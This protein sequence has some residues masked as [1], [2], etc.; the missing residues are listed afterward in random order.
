MTD[1]LFLFSFGPL[2]SFEHRSGVTCGF[3][4][5]YILLFLF[6]VSYSHGG[7]YKNFCH[8]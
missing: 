8:L 1:Y 4:Y 7:D 2:T 3:D 6:F 5:V